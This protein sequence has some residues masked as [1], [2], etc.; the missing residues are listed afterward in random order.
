MIAFFNR[1][2]MLTG[3]CMVLSGS[4]ETIF[5][6]KSHMFSANFEINIIDALS[7]QLLGAF[8][9]LSIG[10]LTPATLSALPREQGVYQLFLAECLV[11]VGKADDLPKR[12]DEHHFKITGRSGL[13]VS[14]VGFKCL[15]VH[16][17][18]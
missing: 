16:K 18:W 4:I 2:S 17:N 13:D 3:T 8:E 12:L 15:Y 10:P 1:K 11:Y 6:W 14:T 7:T 9:K 5:P